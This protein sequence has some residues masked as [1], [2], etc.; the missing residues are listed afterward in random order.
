MHQYAAKRAI[1][2]KQELL[3]ANYAR[4]ESSALLTRLEVLPCL[5]RM[6]NIPA[7]ARLRAPRALLD[8]MQLRGSQTT[9]PCLPAASIALDALPVI[10]ASNLV[11]NCSLFTYPE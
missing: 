9:A 11:R 2:Q 3:L 10:L 5:A 4:R 1:F 8:I 6:V 7:M